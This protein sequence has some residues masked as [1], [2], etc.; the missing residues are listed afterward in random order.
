M[1]KIYKTLNGLFFKLVTLFFLFFT[2]NLL[3]QH[4]DSLSKEGST[5]Q[6]RGRF[7]VA[8][9]KY[10]AAQVI[11]RKQDNWE[12]WLRAQV[13][14]GTCLMI[15]SKFD[16]SKDT[17]TNG[18]RLCEKK[19]AR[20]PQRQHI[21]LSLK[22]GYAFTLTRTGEYV[23]SVD[24]FNEA[25]KQAETDCPKE[26]LLLGQ[27]NRD[28]G[29][30]KLSF[31][32]YLDAQKY[33]T[34]A[35][36]ILGD[37][38]EYDFTIT[39]L[40]HITLGEIKEKLF[41][42]DGALV[43]YQKA[44][45]LQNKAPVK[46][47]PFVGFLTGALGRTYQGLGDYTLAMEYSQRS[48]AIFKT[49]FSMKSLNA[50]N[51]VMQVA[52]IY[53]LRQEWPQASQEYQTALLYIDSL[54]KKPHEN[55]AM[56]LSS[57]AECQ[58][59][60]GL[61]M[62]A[63][64]SWQRSIAE[65]ERLDQQWYLPTAR[66]SLAKFYLKHNNPVEALSELQLAEAQLE[67]QKKSRF[68]DLCRV[69]ALIGQAHIQLKQYDEA[70]VKVK[71]ALVLQCREGSNLSGN[72]NPAEDKILMSGSVIFTLSVKADALY[73]KWFADGGGSELLTS[74]LKTSQLAIRVGERFRHQFQRSV[75]EN[76]EWINQY[77][78]LFVRGVAVAHQLF[79]QTND[80]AYLQQ[81]FTLADRSKALLLSE[82][83]QN[84]DAKLFAGVPR[85]LLDQEAALTRE[86]AYYE[87]KVSE[88]IA[89][90]D[91][92][93]LAQQQEGLLFEKKRAYE[94]LVADM[95]REHP[96]YYEQKYRPRLVSARDIQARLEDK[97]IFIEYLID[98]INRQIYSFAITKSEGLNVN[99]QLMPDG[100]DA[101][102]NNFYRL[103]QANDL[104]SNEKRLQF[105]QASHRLYRI[106]V[107]PIAAYLN[108]KEKMIVV[109]DGLLRY[110]PFE[111]LLSESSSG[112]YSALP[113]LLRKMCLS[114]QYSASLWLRQQ[115]Q[116]NIQP[117]TGLLVFAP[118]FEGPATANA[119][120][121]TPQRLSGS[122]TPINFPPLPYAREEAKTIAQIFNNQPVTLLLEQTATETALK[123]A[124][125]KPYRVVHIASHSFADVRQ[126]KFS[127]IACGM[128]SVNSSVDDNMLYASE[129][130]NIQ[131]RAD[132]IVLSSCE[133]G[134]GRHSD[135]E[136]LLGL[137]RSFIYAGA[138]NIVYSLWSANDQSVGELMTPFYQEMVKNT[139]GTKTYA[140]FLRTAKLK[141]LDD[142]ATACPNKWGGFMLLGE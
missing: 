51:C 120:R 102:L 35:V 52:N 4:P 17:L 64:Q 73:Y 62:A 76:Y 85:A 27:I 92:S 55:R 84:L 37:E 10:K 79:L 22:A 36:E 104:N 13:S 123:D 42:F 114:Y 108:Q 94:T 111:L 25:L 8:I 50:I 2:S 91:V 103:L 71:E 18:M 11:Y 119:T 141:M 133:S 3:A 61:W 124:L 58:I 107:E 65:A 117:R 44:E 23:K 20:H 134:L 89:T 135:S 33:C 59:G 97:D 127:G 15:I 126:A 6:M 57:L 40:A 90:G 118:L 63:V 12:G 139:T 130:Y 138:A 81:A 16:A 56:V 41:D 113:Y 93:P 142:P 68:A 121:Q 28:L 83:L 96:Y 74:S 54:Y 140:P 53:R 47:I 67:P 69:K 131:I 75:D 24:L 116:R 125:K 106:Y 21:Y 98:S 122:N 43:S 32:E 31:G 78:T 88:A 49:L 105:I 77:Q 38:G 86:I 5:S 14:L 115:D 66:E 48:L 100:A 7:D 46:I 99:V 30:A 136:G 45:I 1:L 60:M 80:P 87:K 72:A 70:L 82:G 101:Q 39:I 132:L 137:N 128:L 112:S 29:Y 19:L 34:K 129:L 110:L 109:S 26:Y 9:E 95:E